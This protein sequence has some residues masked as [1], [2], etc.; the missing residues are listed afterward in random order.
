LHLDNLGDTASAVDV[1]VTSTITAS[2]RGWF[3]VEAVD[4]F[5][6]VALLPVT[7]STCIC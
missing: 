1:S 5:D 4:Y 7:I 2:H 3:R 6:V